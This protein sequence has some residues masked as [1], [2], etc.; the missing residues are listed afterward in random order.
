MRRRYNADGDDPGGE[1][2]QRLHP[3]HDGLIPPFSF[4]DAASYQAPLIKSA[5]HWL[6]SRNAARAT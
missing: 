5:G 3:F 1:P 4:H 2:Q 6:Q